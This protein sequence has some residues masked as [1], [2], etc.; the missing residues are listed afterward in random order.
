[1]K[2]RRI[3]SIPGHEPMLDDRGWGSGWAG[4]GTMRVACACGWRGLTIH[5]RWFTPGENE[6]QS[7]AEPYRGFVEHYGVEVMLSGDNDAY[8]TREDAIR[9]YLAHLDYDPD[10]DR[11]RALAAVTE[12]TARLSETLATSAA[13]TDTHARTVAKIG[14][15]TADALALLNTA[16]ARATL[17]QAAPLLSP[18]TPDPEGRRLIEEYQRAQ[19][20]AAAAREVTEAEFLEALGYPPEH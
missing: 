7:F 11:T 20:E 13:T 9:L 18:A 1:M 8:G 19:R 15:A 3:L 4:P 17:W 14:T 16:I 12:A 6:A 2:D 5:E 10:A